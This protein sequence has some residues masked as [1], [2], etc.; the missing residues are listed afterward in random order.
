MPSAY[1]HPDS[2]VQSQAEYDSYLSAML[3]TDGA[4]HLF[5]SLHSVA[6]VASTFDSI[7]DEHP[8]QH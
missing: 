5:R 3:A 1:I 7:G 4:L 6:L 2:G 8:C